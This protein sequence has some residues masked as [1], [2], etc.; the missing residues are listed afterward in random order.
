MNSSRKENILTLALVNIHGQTGLNQSKQM[1]IETFLH[2]HKIDILHLQET[3]ILDDTFRNCNLINSSYN[4]LINNSPTKYGTATLIKSDLEAVNL[5]V[6]AEGR[7]LIFDIGNITFA[8]LYLPSGTDAKSRAGR[9]QYCAETI[10]KLL[11]HSNPTGCIGGDLNS[12]IDKKDATKHP[13]A[14]MSPSFQR[15]AKTFKWQDCFRDLHPNQQI[16]SRYYANARAE[17]ATRID[18]MYHWGEIK[19][20]EAKYCSLAFSDHMAHIVSIFLPD[21]LCRILSPKSRPSYKIKQDVVN[22]SIFQERL[23]DSMD[24]WLEVKSFGLNVIPWWEIVVKPG[25][26]QLA[27]QRSKEINKTKRGE[28]NL[29]F[30]RQAYLTKKIQQCDTGKLSELW[31][32]HGLI[33]QWYSR[34][35]DRVKHQSR[36]SEFQESEKVRIYHHEIHQKYMKKTSILKLETENGLLEGHADCAQYLEKCVEDLLL[37]PVQLDGA[38]QEALLNEVDLVFT[39]A[40]NE[41]LL[42][43]PTKEEVKETLLD[44]NLHAAP[45]TDGLTSF[46]YKECFNI[47]GDPL[48]E[49]VSAVFC[50][51]KPSSSQR[52]S[53]MVFGSKPKKAKSIKPGDKRRISLLNADFKTISGLISRR[54]KKTATRTLSPYQLVAGD[55]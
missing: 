44:S 47:I 15:L 55:T 39:P 16:F 10:P 42:K 32:V 14:K 30:L 4:I 2:H 37:H 28:I 3:N 36:V 24:H 49:V 12:I 26:K 11:I 17:G 46:F 34:E 48:T 51:D 29:L 53:L 5:V 21:Q 35:T 27:I 52:T 1:Q 18:R 7:V 19:V 23:K 6:D 20:K 8:N 38:A 22:D 43:A 31:A 40:D 45:G 13:E 50:G 33:E 9:E 25:V 41:M 54:L